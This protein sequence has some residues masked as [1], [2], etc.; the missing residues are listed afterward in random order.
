[1]KNKLYII[2][3]AILTLSVLLCACNKNE[4]VPSVTANESETTSY[5]TETVEQTDA[6]TQT[7]TYVDESGYHV[8][9]IV[10]PETEK[11]TVPPVPSRAQTPTY[12][13]ETLPHNQGTTK[14][15][16]VQNNA[17][18]SAT[19]SA[20]KVQNA[21]ETQ[22]VT[23]QEITNGLSMLFKTDVV[24]RGNDA[25]ITVSGETGKEYTIEVYRNNTDKLASD[26]L[27]AKN[28]DSNGF[29]SWTFDTDNCESGYRKVIIKESNGEKYIQTSI[30]IN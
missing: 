17:T 14:A 30:K 22:P 26:S 15:D 25:T 18:P 27:K 7:V 4:T 9:S 6:V 16:A 29:V 19:V 20:T 28:A 12:K 24:S 5:V 21:T 23:I 1:M 13:T 8:V 10:V 11:E 3:G 2:S